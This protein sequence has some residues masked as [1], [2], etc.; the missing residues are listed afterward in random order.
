MAIAHC[1]ER[2]LKALRLGRKKAKIQPDDDDA[3][4]PDEVVD[5]QGDEAAADAG[6]GHLDGDEFRGFNAKLI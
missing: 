2:W 6:E 1:S 3:G 4:E 5:Q